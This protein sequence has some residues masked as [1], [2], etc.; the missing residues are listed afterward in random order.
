LREAE[1]SYVH[2]RLDALRLARQAFA[3]HPA[4]GL[5]WENFPA[6]AAREGKYGGL[7]TH[8]EYT[9]IAAELGLPGIAALLVVAL[10]A[11]FAAALEPRTAFLGAAVGVIASGA[12][13][14]IFIN[15]LVA[16]SPSLPLATA[17]GLLVGSTSGRSTQG[18]GAAS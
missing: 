8:N 16:S 6:Y 17:V 9:R 5:G 12:V 3:D 11:V 7:A 1:S 13:A 10:S 18:S 15:G 4:R 2:S 14:L